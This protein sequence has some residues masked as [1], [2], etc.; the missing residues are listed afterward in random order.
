MPP[1]QIDF[2]IKRGRDF[3]QYRKDSSSYQENEI[4]LRK[5]LSNPKSKL[6]QAVDIFKK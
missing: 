4:I 6:E 1:E 5:K 2:S 3:F